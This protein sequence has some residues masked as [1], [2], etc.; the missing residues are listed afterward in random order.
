MLYGTGDD[1]RRFRAN[2]YFDLDQLAMNMRA[3]NNVIRPYKTLE[4]HA[5]VTK[6]LSLAHTKEGLCLVTGITGSGKSSTLD[7]IIDANNR[8]RG[9]SHRHYRLAY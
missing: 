2:A 3:I 9:R 5:N 8:H 1:F 4:L 7:S 6:V